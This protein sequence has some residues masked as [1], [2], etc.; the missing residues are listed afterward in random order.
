MSRY[1]DKSGLRKTTAIWN[2]RRRITT[3]YQNKRISSTRETSRPKSRPKTEKTNLF[4][5]SMENV[6]ILAISEEVKM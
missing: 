1:D 6:Q 3:G 4:N 5:K 2:Y